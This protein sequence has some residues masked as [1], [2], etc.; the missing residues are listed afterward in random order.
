MTSEDQKFFDDARDMFMLPGWEKF[1]Q[2]IELWIQGVHFD[3]CKTSDDFWMSK[4][5]LNALRQVRAYELMVKQAEADAE[6]E[7]TV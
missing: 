7:E 2:E 1:M 5:A 4:G 3:S 6:D